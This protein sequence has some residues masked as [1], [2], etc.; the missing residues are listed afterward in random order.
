M[1]DAR[2][3]PEAEQYAVAFALSLALPLRVRR[4]LTIPLSVSG[5]DER[6]HGAPDHE[7]DQDPGHASESLFPISGKAGFEAG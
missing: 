4:S 6:T 1:A 2:A 3:Y 7:S 5:V